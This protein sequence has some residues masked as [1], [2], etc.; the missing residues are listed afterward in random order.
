MMP[1][2]LVHS[3]CRSPARRRSH[4]CSARRST[5]SCSVTVSGWCSA[6]RPACRASNSSAL[7][8]GSRRKAPPERP[9]SRRFCAT[10]CLPASVRGPVLRWAFARLAAIWA[11][12][13]MCVG[14]LNSRFHSTSACQAF[15]ANWADFIGFLACDWGGKGVRKRSGWP[16][17][18]RERGAGLLPYSFADV[19]VCGRPLCKLS[20]RLLRHRMYAGGVDPAVIEI[21]QGAD[22]DGEIEL[23]VRP[24]QMMQR[25]DVIGCDPGR[26]MIDL[27]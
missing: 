2:A 11:S 24:S 8:H 15:C 13:A 9:C 26:V 19:A 21:E 16:D 5:R 27:D 18:D 20:M 17:R 3:D 23:F 12:V 25:L 7:S 22:G 10:A 4:S 1:S 6:R 14:F